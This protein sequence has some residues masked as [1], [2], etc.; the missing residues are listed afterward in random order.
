M[1]DGQEIYF[2]RYSI[3][4]SRYIVRFWA[5]I[6]EREEDECWEWP[7]ARNTAGYG[8][9]RIGDGKYMNTHRFAYITRIGPLS[10]EE[11]AL[12]TCDNPPC[13]NPNHL[14]KG[15]R[16]DN[17]IDRVAKGRGN[18]VNGISHTN[19]RSGLSERDWDEIY[20]RHINGGVPQKELAREFGV[21]QGTISNIVQKY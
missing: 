8:T 1:L 13:C 19:N 7:G 20:E 5:R 14:F 15:S 9:Y 16:K 11:C 12:H 6:I 4:H 2:L 10:S 21:S 18:F 17:A 3:M